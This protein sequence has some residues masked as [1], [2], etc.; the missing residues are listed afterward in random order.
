MPPQIALE[1]HNTMPPA[2]AAGRR[3][4]PREFLPLQLANVSA[5][6]TTLRDL[7]YVLATRDENTKRNGHV[8]LLLVQ[9]HR[10]LRRQRKMCDAKI[11]R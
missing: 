3:V 9:S 8:V 7:G 5:L 11:S 1:L 2:D 6:G 4:L 10:V